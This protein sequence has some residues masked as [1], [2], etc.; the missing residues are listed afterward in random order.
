MGH[1]R[2]HYLMIGLV[3]CIASWCGGA[4]AQPNVLEAAQAHDMTP[5]QKL[6]QRLFHDVRLSHPGADWAASCASCHI[7]PGGV[8]DR[9]YADDQP[10][11]LIPSG[12]SGFKNTTLRNSPTAANTSPMERYFWDGRYDDLDALLRDKITGPWF[13]WGQGEESA[14]LDEIHQLLVLDTGEQELAEG[15]YKETFAAVYEVDLEELSREETIDQVVRALSDYLGYMQASMTSNWD[16]FAYMNRIQQHVDIATGDTPDAYAGRLE[17][18]L[19]NQ[20]GRNVIKAPEG[21]TREA[22]DGMKIFFRY[23]GTENAGNCVTCH[24]PPHFTDFEFHNTGVSQRAYDA[25]HGEGSFDALELPDA[26]SD[27]TRMAPEEDKPD[28]ADLGYWNYAEDRE[29]GIAAFKTPTLRNL[30]ET[31]PYFHNGSAGSLEDVVRHYMEIGKLAREGKLRNAP[32]VFKQIYLSEEDIPKLV[33][34]LEQL[35]EVGPDH[36]RETVVENVTILKG[37]FY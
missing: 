25:V 15:P 34:F 5:A 35:D 27:A 23:Y 6:G 2:F 8:G 37:P 16:A 9:W 36:Y 26:P 30:R 24:Y 20:E 17:G 29:A 14:A 33:A 11:S 18:N 10:T 22:Y 31:N 4:A 1:I 13:G 28:Q 19:M 21:W 7:P 12:A 32:E 3:V